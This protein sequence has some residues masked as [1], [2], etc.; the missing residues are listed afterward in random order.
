MSTVS[1]KGHGGGNEDFEEEAI[2]GKSDGEI[3]DLD[4]FW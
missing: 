2:E 3:S 1:R 4:I